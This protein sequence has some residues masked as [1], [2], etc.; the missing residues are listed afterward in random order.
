MRC[1]RCGRPVY[2]GNSKIVLMNGRKLREH[3]NCALNVDYGLPASEA[4]RHSDGKKHQARTKPN[5]P[6]EP[7][8]LETSE[9][10]PKLNET[11]RFFI[12]PA[13]RG[14]LERVSNYGPYL[15]P[16]GIEVYSILTGVVE[17]RPDLVEGMLELMIKRE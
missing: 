7:Q 3:R 15:T 14:K 11:H 13:M 6:S 8:P 2:A 12:R 5:L 9:P 16:V 1:V 4:R 10:Q 17:E